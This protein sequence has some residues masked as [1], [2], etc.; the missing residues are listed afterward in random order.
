MAAKRI[1]LKPFLESLPKLENELQEALMRQRNGELSQQTT[2]APERTRSDDEPVTVGFGPN[3]VAVAPGTVIHRFI[4]QLTKRR[5]EI[6]RVLEQAEEIGLRIKRRPYSEYING[7]AET[8][9]CRVESHGFAL[10]VDGRPIFYPKYE[11]F[12]T[13]RHGGNLF[14]VS[15]L[16]EK[17]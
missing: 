2:G 3:T 12:L 4:R 10:W 17:S 7:I 13:K 16:V 5:I 14:H 1:D 11:V 15:P 8:G 6:E 9:I